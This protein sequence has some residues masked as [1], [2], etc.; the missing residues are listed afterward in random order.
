MDEEEYE[1]LV[2]LTSGEFKLA[3]PAFHTVPLSQSYAII[4]SFVG[5]DKQGAFDTAFRLFIDRVSPEKIEE[6]Y[7]LEEKEIVI[8]VANWIGT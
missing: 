4:E 6:L 8:L 3:M 2:D 5:G 1:H 7:S